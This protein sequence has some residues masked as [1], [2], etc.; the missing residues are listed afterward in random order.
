MRAWPAPQA[1]TQFLFEMTSI[2]D[3]WQLTKATYLWANGRFDEVDKIELAFAG[4]GVTLTVVTVAVSVGTG[5]AGAP[6]SI[7]AMLSV[8]GAL[9]VLKKTLKEIFISDPGQILRI[10]GTAA[11]WSF[12]LVAKIL[13]G[14]EGRQQ[15]IAQLVDFKD[16][17]LDLIEHGAASAW[18]LLKAV[19][20][21]MDG[22]KAFLRVRKARAMPCL[23]PDTASLPY[24]R[25]YARLTP[26]NLGI[27][28][29]YAA[30]LCGSGLSDKLVEVVSRADL[31]GAQQELMASIGVK[32]LGTA[33]DFS[34]A[35]RM[36]ANTLDTIADFVKSGQ[37]EKFLKFL[38]NMEDSSA[39][40]KSWRFD[41]MSETL[42]NGF[43]P[44]DE[45]I[46]ALTYIP[47]RSQG[48]AFSALAIPNISN[49]R[50]VYGEAATF[51][52]LK[53]HPNIAR[54]N[55]VDGAVTVD[56][57]SLEVGINVDTKRASN[58]QGL[59]V[60]GSFF[61]GTADSGGPFF[62]EVKNY[63][64]QYR[65][66]DLAKQ[67]DKHFDTRIMDQVNGSEWLTGKPHLHFEWMGSGFGKEVSV[68]SRKEA[69]LKVCRDKVRTVLKHVTP[70]F[71]CSKDITF[72]IISD[73]IDPLT[74]SVN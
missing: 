4:I 2:S 35:L 21:G 15:A 1:A 74:T 43:T 3:V 5:G 36:S 16:V 57:A 24:E 58:V 9:T 60:E 11:R 34:G 51:K 25:L 52:R 68:A 39:N 30:P 17:F 65:I 23:I 46:D 64:S 72:N 22:F 55:P 56:A 66:K 61:E 41:K 49:I 6:G 73:Y 40:M 10:G 38:E 33:E 71:D 12:D 14:K 28:Q 47:L 20:E 27:S 26:L 32:V 54:E 8:K 63:T 19:G 45:L 53:T 62:A 37:G 44:F 31:S 29:A 18:A 42:S 69:V 59:D 67:V 70:A 48:D 7:A 50:G 13:S